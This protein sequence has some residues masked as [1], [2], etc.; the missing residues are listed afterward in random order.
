[1]IKEML[2]KKPNGSIEGARSDA[3]PEAKEYMSDMIKA[4]DK[5][6]GL[7]DLITGPVVGY[8]Q[9]TTLQATANTDAGF[10]TIVFSTGLVVKPLCATLEE[11]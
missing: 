9:Q 5:V 8:D 10:L 7:E 2:S 3:M 11:V 1:M 4:L 6:K